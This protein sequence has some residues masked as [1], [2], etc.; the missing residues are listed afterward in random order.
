MFHKI[1]QEQLPWKLRLLPLH[2]L[3]THTRLSMNIPS[4]STYGIRGLRNHFC[5]QDSLQFALQEVHLPI[6][7]SYFLQNLIIVPSPQFS[8]GPN[9][10][11]GINMNPF[12]YETPLSFFSIL[13]ILRKFAVSAGYSQF[14]K[15]HSP[16][17]MRVGLTFSASLVF[18]HQFLIHIFPFIS[19][20]LLHISSASQ[21]PRS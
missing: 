2:F 4:Y 13:H 8:H 9:D 1:T 19:L 15:I 17:F 5:H 21:F 12:L 10:S 7:P 18:F 20:F 11:S 6:Y 16:L 14:P 3:F